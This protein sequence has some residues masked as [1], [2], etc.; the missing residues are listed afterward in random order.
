M[1]T[2]SYGNVT[3]FP[4]W[5]DAEALLRQSR[6]AFLRAQIARGRYRLDAAAIA[7]ALE[8]A[9]ALSADLELTFR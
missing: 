6:V 3:S 9:G 7:E 4:G 5:K 8:S 1:P 2:M